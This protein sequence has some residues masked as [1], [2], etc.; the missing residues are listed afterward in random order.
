[1]SGNVMCLDVLRALGREPDEARAVLAAL[2]RADLP[3]MRDAAAFVA[4]TLGAPD[5]ESRARAAVEP[6]A[7]RAAAAALAESAPAP[8]ADLFATTRLAR[9]RGAT[10]G[11]AQLDGDAM[12]LLLSRALAG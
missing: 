1:G 9:R 4:A 8:I 11:T 12:S 10:Y 2:A 7:L 5:A 6:L 3:G